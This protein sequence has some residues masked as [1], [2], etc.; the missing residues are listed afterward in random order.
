[1]K[2]PAKPLLVMLMGT[3]LL[4]AAAPAFAQSTEPA[5]SAP[6]AEGD[7]RP[8]GDGEGWGWGRRHGGH[9]GMGH[10]GKHGGHHRGPHGIRMTMIIDANADGVIGADEAASLAEGMF[11]RLDQNRDEMLD[12]AEFTTHPGHGGWRGWFG[13]DAAEVEAVLKVRKDRFAALDTSKD[14]K[15]SKVEV[16]AEMQ[17]KLASADADKDGKVTPWEFRALPRM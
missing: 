7:A 10:R 16:F 6:T 17:Q 15:L 1:M 8:E 11:T 12:E 3:T 9:M 14:G 5:S 13:A 4:A 2:Y